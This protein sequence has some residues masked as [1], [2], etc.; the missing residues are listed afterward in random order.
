MIMGKKVDTS[1]LEKYREEYEAGKITQVEIQKILGICKRVFD[2]HIESNNW[3]IQLAFQNRIKLKRLKRY[4]KIE[5]YK[6]DYESGFITMQKICKELRIKHT[7]VRQYVK[8]QNWNMEANRQKQ[9]SIATSNLKP[10]TKEMMEIGHIANKKR[11]ERLHK[12]ARNRKKD[13]I[14]YM[15]GVAF[16]WGGFKYNKAIISR[17]KLMYSKHTYSDT[18]ILKLE[19]CQKRI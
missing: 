18:E 8:E 7:I 6:N 14:V 19:Q 16:V 15:N 12:F 1:I 17:A 2:I 9:I 5:K 13:D 10:L 4:E 3:N 11:W